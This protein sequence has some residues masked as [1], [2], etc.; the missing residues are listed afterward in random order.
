M[1]NLWQRFTYLWI[2]LIGWAAFIL[3]EMTQTVLGF[4]LGVVSGI[5]FALG[6][7]FTSVVRIAR[8]AKQDVVVHGVAWTLAVALGFLCYI[9]ITAVLSGV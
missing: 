8:N 7:I 2:A 3:L 6:A 4:W 9:Y 5:V 1:N